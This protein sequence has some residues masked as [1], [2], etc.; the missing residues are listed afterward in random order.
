M[1]YAPTL[2]FA[3]RSGA[4]VVLVHRSALAIQP[5]PEERVAMVW[6]GTESVPAL[7]PAVRNGVTVEQVRTF[8]L[9][10]R[11][12]RHRLVSSE[13]P[14]HFRSHGKN[15]GSYWRIGVDD[16]NHM[17]TTVRNLGKSIRLK[18]IVVLVHSHGNTTIVVSV[19]YRDG[20]AWFLLEVVFG[21]KPGLN[22]KTTFTN[23]FGGFSFSS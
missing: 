9:L 15:S 23:K 1:A 13:R 11:Q 10:R 7:Y 17:S 22:P 18:T 2:L 14:D 12:L 5:L 4:G 19:T 16:A 8:V 6:W 3:V 20:R 21:F